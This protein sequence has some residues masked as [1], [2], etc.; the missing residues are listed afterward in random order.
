MSQQ[1]PNAGPHV[2]FFDVVETIF[3]LSRLNEKMTA[4]NLPPGIDQV[5]FAHLLRDAFALS[6]TGIFHTFPEI[7]KATL[8]VLLD[9]LDYKFDDTITDEI[10]SAFS[11][12]TAHEDVKAALEKLK[13]SDCRAVL[14]TNGSRE[15]TEK[16]L[17]NNNIEHLVDDIV[18]VE[19]FGVWKPQ[20]ELYRRAARKFSCDPDKALL[21]AAHA[22]DVH[23]AIQA[24][25]HG[26]WIQRQETLYHPLMGHPDKVI[27]LEDA[28]DLA[29]ERL[30]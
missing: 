23:G 8:R 9:S 14:L 22:W 20:T 28:V 30:L 11:Q 24:G 21:I 2:V 13:L 19:E 17:Q 4:F 6:A 18:S 12:L 26:I 29:L 15:N 25:L 1:I 3:S 27:N 7:A 5:F 10:L 16:L